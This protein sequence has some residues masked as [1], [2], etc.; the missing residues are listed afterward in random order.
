MARRSIVVVTLV[1]GVVA[2]AAGPTGATSPPEW[3][4]IPF[5]RALGRDVSVADVA[6]TPSG[7]VVAGVSLGTPGR[8]ASGPGLDL[9]GRDGLAA[10]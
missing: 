8:D 10:R 1:V 2:L 6:A 9:A 4:R 3:Q 5:G 7:F